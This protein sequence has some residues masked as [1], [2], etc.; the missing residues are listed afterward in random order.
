MN[1]WETPVGSSRKQ[2]DFR[3]IFALSPGR[4]RRRKGLISLCL[5]WN[6]RRAHNMQKRAPMSLFE[7]TRPFS[8]G[9]IFL[10]IFG[11]TGALGPGCTGIATLKD[12]L[13]AVPA[14]YSACRA[15]A[16]SAPPQP[17]R[18]RNPG[19]G[20]ARIAACRGTAA[21]RPDPPHARTFR[22][23][24]AARFP[25]GKKLRRAAGIAAHSVVL[26]PLTRAVPG[27]SRRWAAQRDEVR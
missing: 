2:G 23:A 5:V 8:G 11:Q 4:I 27:P 14:G 16:G 19:G 26:C 12:P 3:H 9:E 25:S 18:R 20:S 17:R 15:R 7:R 22:P 10:Q 6:Y 24:V 13:S 21:P 1:L